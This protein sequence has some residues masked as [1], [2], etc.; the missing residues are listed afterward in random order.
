MTEWSQFV[1]ISISLILG[2]LI[3]GIMLRWIMV[4]RNI[5]IE[6]SK[7]EANTA[8]MREYREFNGYND[9]VVY[10][11]DIVSLVLHQR[12]E[13]GVRILKGTTL[14]TYWC[15]NEDIES[16]LEEC[17]DP[18]LL[19][20]GSKQTTYTATAVQEKLDVNRVYK[21]TITYGLNGEVIGVT[22]HQG[23]INSSGNFIAD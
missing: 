18:W 13:V 3:L 6:L 5:N 20:S 2:S 12:G 4:G 7:Q 9:K 22:F 19:S 14:N 15:D 1:W 23:T 10:A 8:L 16:A 21:G 11:Q 17:D